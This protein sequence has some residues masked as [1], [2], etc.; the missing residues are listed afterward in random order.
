M[1]RAQPAISLER[2]G[3]ELL[4][5]LG[6]LERA[7]DG[8]TNESVSVFGTAIY[9]SQMSSFES[10]CLLLSERHWTTMLDKEKV[11]VLLD[12]LARPFKKMAQGFFR[13]PE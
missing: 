4:G 8:L 2:A 10:N 7:S 5:L 9:A 12:K 13:I 11:S 6:L 3:I 1:N